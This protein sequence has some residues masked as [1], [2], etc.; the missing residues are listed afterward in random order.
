MVTPYEDGIGHIIL[1]LH[2]IMTMT[3]TTSYDDRKDLILRG[4][5]IK[6]FEGDPIA[7]GQFYVNLSMN[8]TFC[9]PLSCH[10]LLSHAPKL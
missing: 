4:K 8:I 2:V 9:R 3:M 6:G 5:G 10:L 7:N 1:R